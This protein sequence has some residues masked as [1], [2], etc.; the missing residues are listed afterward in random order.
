[1]HLR[2]DTDTTIVLSK[3]IRSIPLTEANFKTI[4]HY[5]HNLKKIE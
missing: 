3:M 5:L 2:S 4:M 1:M